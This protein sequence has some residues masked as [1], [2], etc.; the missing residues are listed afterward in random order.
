MYVDVLGILFWR[1]SQLLCAVSL[2]LDCQPLFCKNLQWLEFHCKVGCFSKEN[3]HSAWGSYRYAIMPCR[4]RMTGRMLEMI[5]ESQ[6][7]E[8]HFTADKL[9]CCGYQNERTNDDCKHLLVHLACFV[10]SS[11]HLF[12]CQWRHDI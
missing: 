6:T 1:L 5:V 8:R 9:F 2:L 12:P 3:L 4:S 10:L 7:A 11:Y